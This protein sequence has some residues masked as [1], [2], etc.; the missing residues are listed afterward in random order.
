MSSRPLA[1]TPPFQLRHIALIMA[2]II[3]THAYADIPVGTEANT[4]TFDPVFLNGTG[5]SPD[6]AEY[7]QAA[8]LLVDGKS[9]PRNVDLSNGLQ[10]VDVARGAVKQVE[11]KESTVRR[12]LLKITLP[13]GSLAAEGQAIV[14]ETGVLVT[15]V[16]ADSTAFL[17]DVQNN[18]RYMLQGAKGGSCSLEI[19][20]PKKADLNRYYEKGEAT[21]LQ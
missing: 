1:S 18:A 7:Y 8:Q 17:P 5:I 10:T 15:T 13:D 19:H 3:A 16:A 14:D 6:V 20:L 2:S 4:V 21:C 12:A 9:L 11:F